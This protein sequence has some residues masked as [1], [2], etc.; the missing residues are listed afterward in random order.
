MLSRNVIEEFHCV[1]TNLE[2]RFA[3]AEEAA[4]VRHILYTA[5]PDFGVPTNTE[6]VFAFLQYVERLTEQDVAPVM[7][8]CSAGIG[9]TGT[10]IAAA[11]LIPFKLGQHVPS[12]W[13]ESV[14]GPIDSRWTADAVVREID[15]LREQR[16]GMV[17]KEEQMELIYE[18]LERAQG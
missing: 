12:R 18:V 7:V 16:S 9:R 2:L 17:Q 4:T 5:W 3:G 1:E 14:L 6:S 10:F 15:S 13:Q 8:G 11:S